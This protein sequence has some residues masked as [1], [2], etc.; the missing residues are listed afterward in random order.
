MKIYFSN[1]QILSYI[2]V[3]IT[4]RTSML[5]NKQG[6]VLMKIWNTDAIKLK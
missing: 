6:D 5:L 3:N 1:H 4:V 2:L